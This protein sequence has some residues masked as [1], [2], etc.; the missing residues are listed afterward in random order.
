MRRPL[1]Q[2]QQQA[3]RTK[4]KDLAWPQ[5]QPPLPDIPVRSCA[6]QTQLEGRG[7]KKEKNPWFHLNLK[8]CHS[9]NEINCGGVLVSHRATNLELFDLSLG[10]LISGRSFGSWMTISQLTQNSSACL[11]SLCMSD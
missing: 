1:Y 5:Y 11:N 8:L 10:M 2:Q 4:G 9:E 7:E 6:S 3:P